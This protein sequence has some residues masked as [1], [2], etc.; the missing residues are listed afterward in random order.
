MFES[1]L[2]RLP[3]AGGTS[4]SVPELTRSAQGIVS[5]ADRLNG[6]LRAGTNRALE[7]QIDAEV[8]D[9]DGEPGVL[10]L[11]EVW[12]KVGGDFR[13]S[14]RASDELVRGMTGL[15]LGI[16]KVIKES[17][18]EAGNGN[19]MRMSSEEDRRISPDLGPSGNV[20]RRSVDLSG[21]RS[22]D[23]SGRRSTESRRSWELPRERMAARAESI[24]GAR[25]PSALN[26]VRSSDP[27]RDFP[28]QNATVTPAS[29]MRRLFS[30]REQREQQMNANSLAAADSQETLQGYEP[31][32]TP[33]SRQQQKQNTLLDRSRT[34]PPLSIPSPL[35]ALPSEV[36]LNRSK[37]EKIT[38]ARERRK[39]SIA[40]ISTVKASPKFPTISTPNPTT[41]ITPHTVSNSPN[42]RSFPLPRSDSENSTRTHGVTF[43]RPPNISVSA[44]TGLQ[45]QQNRD[46][47]NRTISTSSSIANELDSNLTPPTPATPLSGSETERDS[48]R[49]TLGA[50]NV[51]ASLDGNGPS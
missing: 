33:A 21:R 26:I 9:A 14:L 15:L 17:M 27:D 50:R 7:E 10:D 38:P 31:S 19:H 6:L 44:L 1:Y 35:P 49:R 3:Q 22:V 36:L 43:S 46:N 23:L 24:F 28:P 41:A 39:V 18:A 8:G 4:G 34:L 13:E 12:R 48:R 2:S 20:G 40:S 47:R 37:T 25:P 32:P 30:P 45:Q 29:S 5:A 11:V 51:R 16:G 42:N